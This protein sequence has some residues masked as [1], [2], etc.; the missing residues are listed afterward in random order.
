MMKTIIAFSFDYDDIENIAS[1]LGYDVVYDC[2]I[3]YFR[4]I[5]TF[6]H[7]PEATTEVIKTV[8][9]KYSIMENLTEYNFC[10]EAGEQYW[11]KPIL[12]M[13]VHN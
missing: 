1:N 6:E 8:K 3:L 9:E 4:N 2:G 12:L 13:P 5:S 11:T 10:C 7:E